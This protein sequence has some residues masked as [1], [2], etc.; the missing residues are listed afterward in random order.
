MVSLHKGCSNCTHEYYL[1]HD[2]DVIIIDDKQIIKDLKKLLKPYKFKS[3]KIND[4]QI[5]LREMG[6]K[7]YLNEES[8]LVIINPREYLEVSKDGA[9]K[10]KHLS[11]CGCNKKDE[12]W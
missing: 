3:F 7:G 6:L 8:Q 5:I 4:L 10:E 9:F 11:D 12:G 1:K 2:L